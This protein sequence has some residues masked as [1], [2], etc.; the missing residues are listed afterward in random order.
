MVDLGEDCE[1]GQSKGGAEF[2][3][4][5]GGGGGGPRDMRS[6]ARPMIQDGAA[7]LLSKLL[8]KGGGGGGERERKW[9]GSITLS[10]FCPGERRVGEVPRDQ[11]WLTKGRGE[12]GQ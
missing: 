3:A 2:V 6:Q 12:R 11:G 10:P 8:G 5:G 9:A 7:A 1:R 4:G